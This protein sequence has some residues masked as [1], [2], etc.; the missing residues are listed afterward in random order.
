[1]AIPDVACG[2]LGVAVGSPSCSKDF[3]Q[4]ATCPEAYGGK[5]TEDNIVGECLTSSFELL[6]RKGR[7]EEIEGKELGFKYVLEL[8]SATAAT[9]PNIHHLPIRNQTIPRLPKYC[10]SRTIGRGVSD[11]SRHSASQNTMPC[12]P[13]IR[14][15]IVCQTEYQTAYCLPV[16]AKLQ[17]GHVTDNQDELYSVASYTATE[18]MCLG[19]K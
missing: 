2:G 14:Q 6:N 13:N 11:W 7:R 4:H 8:D 19:R 12:N 3:N 9:R 18:S 5:L 16:S 1:M 17:P 15:P 10:R